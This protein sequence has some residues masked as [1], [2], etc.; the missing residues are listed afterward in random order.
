MS[1]STVD[2]SVNTVPDAV[3]A[4]KVPSSPNAATRRRASKRKPRVALWAAALF[5]A[6]V[7]LAVIV[8]GLLAPY[9][10]LGIDLAHS[11]DAP[12]AT[13]WFG[14]DQSGRDVLSRVI[15]GARA[16]VLIGV[17]ATA[18]GLLGAFV[19]GLLGGLSGR[20]VD[21]GVTWV[22]EVL[23]AFPGILLAL[24]LIAVFG[25]SAGTQ[26]VAVGLSTI[27]GYAR[28][29]RGQV[30]SVKNAAYVQAERGLGHG[31]AHVLFRT[32]L[33][34]AFKPLTVLITL[35]I[36]QAIVWAAALGFLGMG[37]Q[38]PAAEW[39]AM[40][41]AGRNYLQQAWWA[42]FFPGVVI[43]LLALSLTTL[44]RFIQAKTQPGG[45][46]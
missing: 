32:L 25:N 14:T 16:S 30:L 6:L 33:P 4:P 42:D 23:Y 28:M 2:R 12:S 31:P 46:A 8:P 43:V 34:N 40:L 10:P 21:S 29:V 20:A 15:Y 17:G 9:D 41:N 39:G 35:G 11:F 38:P 37:V 18:V 26:I 44:G 7:L 19:L 22:I 24:V 13:H 1:T 27:P 36:G 45:T 5:T 3:E